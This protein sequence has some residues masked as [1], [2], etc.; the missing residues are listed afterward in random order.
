MSLK[1]LFSAAL[2]LGSA[3]ASAQMPPPGVPHGGLRT[4]HSVK[5]EGQR[6]DLRDL[7]QLEQ[8][9]D[10]MG[11]IRGRRN[12]PQMRSVDAD[13]RAY[14]NAEW[15][16]S[17]REQVNPNFRGPRDT[18]LEQRQLA[19]VRSIS[20]ELDRLYGRYD[21]R[22]WDRRRTLVN[23]LVSLARAELARDG[24]DGRDGRPVTVHG[25][26]NHAYSPVR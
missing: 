3:L 12:L 6:D 4:G 8:I 22:S 18:R 20:A 5:P 9:R 10:R 19:Q 24:R 26:E 25:R 16:E 15:K 11:A 1:G 7:Q 21:M 13:L 14:V 17:R 2:L 23:E